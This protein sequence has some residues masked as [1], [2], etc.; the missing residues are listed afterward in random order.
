MTRLYIQVYLGKLT[1]HKKT[2]SHKRDSGA[3]EMRYD[4]ALTLS[5]GDMS[6]VVASLGPWCY[7]GAS[8]NQET[9]Q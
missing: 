4:Y 8:S 7:Y 6:V 9:F 5:K 3:R 2:V 1:D